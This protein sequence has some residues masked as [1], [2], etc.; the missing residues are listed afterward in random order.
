MGLGNTRREKMIDPYIITLK[1]RSFWSRIKYIIKHF[2]V[3][4]RMN[5]RFAWLTLK[6]IEQNKQ[7]KLVRKIKDNPEERCK[8]IKFIGRHRL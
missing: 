1:E 4:G 5:W 8:D 3:Y 2:K 6:G 7:L